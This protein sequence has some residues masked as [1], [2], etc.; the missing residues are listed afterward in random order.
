MLP[1][2]LE[3]HKSNAITSEHV[4]SSNFTPSLHYMIKKAKDFGEKI[5]GST[6][7]LVME[8]PSEPLLPDGLVKF[9]HIVRAVEIAHRKYMIP[10]S[11]TTPGNLYFETIQK[12]FHELAEY[13]E[14]KPDNT[15]VNMLIKKSYTHDESYFK[16]PF[17]ALI[18]FFALRIARGKSELFIYDKTRF[19]DWMITV[20]P[21]KATWD[22]AVDL[23]V[24]KEV[25]C[26]AIRE[27]DE[28][29][30]KEHLPHF[31]KAWS[32]FTTQLVQERRENYCCF[33]PSISLRLYLEKLPTYYK[34]KNRMDWI[35]QFHLKFPDDYNSVI[36]YI[37]E[38]PIDEA[39][40]PETIKCYLYAKK[41]LEYSCNYLDY[42]VANWFREVKICKEPIPVL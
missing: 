13:S 41:T 25:I 35:S 26:T 12:L 21:L 28:P 3:T 33:C 36:H 2:D 22:A 11:L 38:I 39:T 29:L 10:P 6:P 1:C 32:T 17:S 9:A 7:N 16:M 24:R 8:E 15:S 14:E 4:S 31:L 30:L 40:N 27:N 20:S 42:F 34:L 19:D 5:I 37:E 18:Y 23:I